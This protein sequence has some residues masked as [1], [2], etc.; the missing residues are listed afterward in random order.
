M[1]RLQCK[2]GPPRPR[3]VGTT[4]HPST[5]RQHNMVHMELMLVHASHCRRPSCWR[6]HVQRGSVT[7]PGRARALGLVL[8]SMH[9]QR[10]EPRLCTAAQSVAACT[11]C[12][13]IL[14]TC[15]LLLSYSYNQQANV[16]ASAFQASNK[17]PLIESQKVY[18]RQLGMHAT[19][20]SASLQNTNTRPQA[21]WPH[22]WPHR[23]CRTTA[24]ISFGA[25]Q[26]RRVG[27]CVLTHTHV[28]TSTSNNN[29]WEGQG[30]CRTTYAH[31][32]TQR[33]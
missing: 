2:G 5:C 24:R 3:L 13:C 14:C 7:G 15:Q 32:K 18:T 26:T 4:T 31:A 28:A 8:H 25:V 23:L 20:A 22:Q 11:H 10:V 33:E 30:L 1:Q 9:S 29:N 19:R 12:P 16:T 6:R 27:A 17:R 21:P